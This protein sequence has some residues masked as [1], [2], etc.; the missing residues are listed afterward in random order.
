MRNWVRGSMLHNPAVPSPRLE[1]AGL[2]KS[3]GQRVV[4]RDL[5]FSVGV[6]ECYALLGPNGAGKSTT[7]R[8]IQGLTAPD[9]GGVYLDGRPLA[10][11]PAGGHA[12]MGVVA[13]QDQLD[14]D[15][16]VEENLWT[17][18]RYFRLPAALIRQ[19]SRELLAFMALEEF[20]QRPI[21]SLSGGMRRR[22]SVA[23]ALIHQ[24]QLLLLDE[25]TTGLDPQAR[26]LLW[27]RLRALQRE[28]VTLLLTTHY[29]DEAERL[30]DR[31]GILQHG[32]ILAEDAPVAMIQKHIP[33]E[34][35]EL[36]RR[37]GA[38][39]DAE[40][41]HQGRVAAAERS[42]DTLF[43]FD[44]QPERVRAHFA[45]DPDYQLLQRPATLEDV[46]LRLTG[47]EL[48]EGEE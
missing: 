28:G 40:N 30:A 34:V 9:A 6:G 18:G 16:T 5:S 15:F 45:A 35:L 27:Q 13:Q 22:L 8:C 12:R 25:P 29:L 46:F 47:R 48:R 31:V 32:S 7:I 43:L 36:R 38:L 14:P 41:W 21:Q 26:H 20:A 3:Y 24:P 44:P 1:V 42:G 10:D 4:L 33:G 19:R 17:Y 2:A 11:W 23:R 37:D 39:P